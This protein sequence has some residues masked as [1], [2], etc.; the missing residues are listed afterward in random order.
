MFI[1]HLAKLEVLPAKIL[2]R[3]T[4]YFSAFLYPFED[5][6][7][8]QNQNIVSMFTYL[9]KLGFLPA[10]ISVKLAD[11]FSAFLYPFEDDI[12]KQSQKIFCLCSYII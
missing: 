6:I 2:V 7:L 12:L 4:D 11:Y 10:K 5:D 3:L 8:K 1:Y 9:T